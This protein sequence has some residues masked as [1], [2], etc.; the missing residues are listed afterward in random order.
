[1]ADMVEKDYNHPCVILYSTG[2]EVAETA[3]PKGIALAREITDFLH[4]MDDTRPVTC[5]INIFFNFL[6]SIGFGQYSDEKAAKEA[7]KAAKAKA[8]GKKAKERSTGSKFFND[9]AG[10][11]GADFMK[12][13]AT[14]HG[15]DV[16][17]RKAF[18]NMDIAGYNYGEK[19]YKKDLK[20]YPNRLILGSETFCFDAYKFWELA[21]ENPRLIGDFVWA[22]FDYLGEVMVGSW[23]YEE[24]AKNFDAGL[25]WMSAGSGRIDLTG[26]PLGE[27]LYTKVA[28]ELEKGPYIAV[29]PL[30]HKK[31]S[32]S[33]SAWKMTNAQPSWS[34]RGWEG[35]KAH[36]EVYARAAAVELFLNGTSVGK[37]TM[38]NDCLFHFHVPYE[39]GTLEAVSYDA[40]GREIS[41]NALTIAGEE[42]MLRAVP[43]QETVQAGHLCYIR[44]QY[45]D[46]NGIVKPCERGILDVSVTGGK[47]VGL[48]SA[49]PYYE[50]DYRG[51]RADAY[52]GEAL[53]IVEADT[54]GTMTLN[55]SDGKQIA[56]VSVEVQA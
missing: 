40:N 14:L 24:Y 30:C 52:Y 49:C 38:K 6:N 51:S 18:A 26:K 29:R 36:V 42:T 20:K 16:T 56:T 46:R 22:G 33:P 44:L 11:L 8:E 13:G 47:L 25:G 21:K 34:W 23:E 3:Q 39:N 54:E 7:E 31:K 45:T 48:G 53:A 27:A 1:M 9:M 32:H 50:L 43:E 17:T 19:R 15:S 37:K 12:I 4:T 28:F 5:G 2:N 10:I 35:K 55:V 41:R